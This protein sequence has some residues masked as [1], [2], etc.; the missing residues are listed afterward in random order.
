M[1]SLLLL[2]L[3]FAG[4]LV[5]LLETESTNYILT[6]IIFTSMCFILSLQ[7]ALRERSSPIDHLCTNF[8]KSVW[9]MH[10][11]PRCPITIKE[12]GKEP[13]KW[14]YLG[15]HNALIGQY[16]LTDCC[17]QTGCAMFND[18]DWLSVTDIRDTLY[19]CIDFFI[20]ATHSLRQEFLEVWSSENSL[21][22]FL[23][24]WG[25][26]WETRGYFLIIELLLDKLELSM[27]KVFDLMFVWRI[28]NF[29]L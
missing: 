5:F 11:N 10:T 13:S 27:D 19:C 26:I 6:Q 7:S 24:R 28:W 8:V 14:W 21:S 12:W 16:Y 1:R 4:K 22:R 20:P 2:L 18:S 23:S 25:H 17:E 29:V 9:I 15:T 3:L